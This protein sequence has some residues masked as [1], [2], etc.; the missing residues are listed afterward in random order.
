MDVDLPNPSQTS[1]KTSIQ[2][3]NFPWSSIP[4]LPDILP[5]IIG[6]PLSHTHLRQAIR[7]HFADVDALFPILS[8]IA[9]WLKDGSGFEWVKS[10]PVMRVD[11]YGKVVGGPNDETGN[12]KTYEKRVTVFSVL[13]TET[14]LPPIDAVSRTWLCIGAHLTNVSLSRHSHSLK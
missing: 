12:A 3:S 14:G 4:R 2:T 5:S 11:R 10:S 8:Q 9:K 6:Y 13:R 1:S 7:R